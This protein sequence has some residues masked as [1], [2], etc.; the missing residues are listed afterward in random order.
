MTPDAVDDI[1]GMGV[2]DTVDNGKP[3]IVDGSAGSTDMKSAYGEGSRDVE[4]TPMDLDD[5]A[6]GDDAEEEHEPP[7]AVRNPGQPTPAEVAEHNLTHIPFRPWC[8]HC[9]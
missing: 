9:V 4:C 1:T 8:T 2:E 5:D 7:R 6:A 3:Q